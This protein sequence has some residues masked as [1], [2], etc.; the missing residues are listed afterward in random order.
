MTAM[1]SLFRA[2]F[3]S[4]SRSALRGLP[5][6]LPL[7]ACLLLPAGALGAT[8]N[9]TA[10]NALNAAVSGTAAGGTVTWGS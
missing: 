10:R 7:L 4:F 9:G 3:H 6:I 2:L 8:V 1:P 5:A